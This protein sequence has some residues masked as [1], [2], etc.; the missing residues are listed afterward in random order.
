MKVVIIYYSILW[1]YF[2]IGPLDYFVV[3]FFSIIRDLEGYLF[4]TIFL[5]KLTLCIFPLLK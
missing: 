2:V 3:S 1:S 4:Y 5:S